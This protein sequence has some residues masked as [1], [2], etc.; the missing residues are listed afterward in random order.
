[1][2][3]LKDVK[4]RKLPDF[5]IPGA[6]KGGTTSA[7]Y[8]LDQHPEIQMSRLKEPFYFAY[9]GEEAINF[10]SGDNPEIITS[11]ADYL[12][13]FPATD[14]AVAR[15]ESSTWY[16]YLHKKTIENIKSIYAGQPLPKI[17]IFLR[18]PVARCWSHYRMNV[19]NGWEDLPFEQA[20]SKDIIKERL[21]NNYA[22][23][24]D[25]IGF[26]R[27]YQQVK[28]YLDNFDQVKI[29]LFEDFKAAPEK[30]MQELFQ[31][32]GVNDYF[33]PDTSVRFN[34]SGPP[35]NR[36]LNYI[37]FG[38][39]FIKRLFRPV[40]D[41]LNSIQLVDNMMLRI[42]ANNSREISPDDQLLQ[43]LRDTYQKNIHKLEKKLTMD[44]G[45]WY[46]PG[47]D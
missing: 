4:Q 3:S 25:Y 28:A 2:V 1:M 32:I 40:V 24:Y 31:F 5:I 46:T 17:I 37:L 15:G 18:N 16:L 47:Q 23:T 27:Y 21:K 7:Y 36:A 10:S 41:K 30:T 35:K 43:K 6:A 29:V 42:R 45:Q 9:A 39:H 12:E 38:D 8:Y 19:D 13:L 33:L 14:T 26:G 22:P 11:L 44:L 20:I 34:V